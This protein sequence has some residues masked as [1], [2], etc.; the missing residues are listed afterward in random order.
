M[1]CAEQQKE[2]VFSWIH[3]SLSN[4]RHGGDTPPQGDFSN[5]HWNDNARK[6]LGSIKSDCG[7]LGEVKGT[8]APVVFLSMLV[9]EKNVRRKAPIEQ[10]KIG[11]QNLCWWQGLG[12]YDNGTLF[13]DHLVLNRDGIHI[14]TQGKAILS[15]KKSN[16]E[17]RVLNWEWWGNEVI[18]KQPCHLQ[19]LHIS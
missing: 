2:K 13:A 4:L 6:N 5:T 9:W 12:F 14:T 17:I 8:W 3:T 15:N 16:L 18:N 1:V 10:V 7:V 11:L 19:H